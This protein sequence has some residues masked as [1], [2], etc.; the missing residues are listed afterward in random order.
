RH[1]TLTL[2]DSGLNLLHYNSVHP[3]GNVGIAAGSN[4]LILLDGQYS[5]GAYPGE[6]ANMYLKLMDPSGTV[7]YSPVIQVDTIYTDG[8][9]IRLEFD[10]GTS[11]AVKD[12][13][14]TPADV[15]DIVGDSLE[16]V[17]VQDFYRDGDSVRLELSDGTKWAVLDSFVD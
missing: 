8:D 3:G 12:S 5:Q 6:L 9:S 14:L 10:N 17:T 13:V 7:K 4:G 2:D 1:S 16:I 15:M 11:L